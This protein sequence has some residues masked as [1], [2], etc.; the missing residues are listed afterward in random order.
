MT[1]AS[2]DDPYEEVSYPSYVHQLSN[3]DHLGAVGMLYG[4]RTPDP[5]TASVLEV[6]CSSGLNLISI[7]AEQPG[8]RCVGFDITA[9]A[10]AEGNALVQSAGLTNVELLQADLLDFPRDGE[11]FDYILCHG[12]LAWVPPH[13]RTALLEVIA[14]R[15]A[16]GGVALVSYDALPAAANKRDIVRFLIE[17]VAGIADPIARVD[18]ALG[19]IDT[20][21]ANQH[22][23]SRL[24]PQLDDLIANYE[25]FARNYFIHDWLA[26]FYDPL[27]LRDFA[28]AASKVGLAYAGD[29][30]LKDRHV[31]DID[32][33]GRDL[34][35]LHEGSLVSFGYTLDLLRGHRMFRVDLLV[36]RDA[37]PPPLPTPVSPSFSTTAVRQEG[38]DDQGRRTLTLVL[39]GSPDAEI[40]EE[41]VRIIDY[42]C[43]RAPAELNFEDMARDLGDNDLKPLLE[44]LALAGLLEIHSTPQNFTLTPGERPL[45][46]QLAR[47]MAANDDYI[48]SLRH[49]RERIGQALSSLVR[50]ADGTRTRS[51]IGRALVGEGNPP[52]DPA[53]IDRAIDYLARKRMF[54]A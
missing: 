9:S 24:K 46:T 39:D 2:D 6:G 49:R 43:D 5:R 22:Q 42:I 30:S 12:L 48:P 47:A 23:K 45:A 21:G 7:A 11:K 14:G 52:P 37:P 36:Q 38:V 4:W 19:I 54:N 29:A 44:R 41:F 8:C 40:G 10:I 13:V 16:P 50:L 33:A 25:S 32:E 31:L 35:K 51:E 28:D 20:L 18:S 15:L 1:G 27:S 34:L 3:P 17:H 26:P 53:E